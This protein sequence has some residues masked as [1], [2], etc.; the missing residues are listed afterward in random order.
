MKIVNDWPP[1]FELIRKRFPIGR[2]TI[3]TYGDSIYNPRNTELDEHIVR[4]EAVHGQ[5]QAD[6]AGGPAAWW[7]RYI[8]DPAF[9]LEQ[10]LEAYRVQWEFIKT[11]VTDRNRR[12]QILNLLAGELS[13]PLY[14]S[15]ISRA[16]AIQAIDA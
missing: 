15:L 1:N 9:R 4:H 12:F 7:D 11:E 16:E 10:E 2:H 13:S 3:F 8:A 5:Q 6:Y 14:G